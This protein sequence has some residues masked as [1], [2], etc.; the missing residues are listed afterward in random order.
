MTGEDTQ[1]T[2]RSADTVIRGAEV[3]DGSGSEA[4]LADVAI[5]DER[6][7]AVGNLA[8]VVAERDISAHGKV[9]APASSTFTRMTTGSC[10]ADPT[11]RQ[12]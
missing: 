7:V 12:R 5:I 2:P 11:W 3:Y 6:I 10:L 9:L 4:A 1:T 8:S